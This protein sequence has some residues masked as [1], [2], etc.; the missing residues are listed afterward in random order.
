MDLDRLY[1][2]LRETTVQLRKGEVIHGDKPLVDALKAAKAPEDYEQLPGGVV[3]IDAMP[4]VSEAWP[5]LERVDLEFLVIGVNKA[6]AEKHRAEFISILNEY[7]QPDRLAGGPS[8]IEV[9]AEIGDQGAAFQL[10]ALGKVLGIWDVIT[11]A[12]MGFTGA[13]AQQMAG[14]GMVMM[15][16][17]Q[18]AA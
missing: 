3:T 15:T 16:G 17:Y 8:Y 4:H 11:P 13:V 9:G 1:E 7:P 14:A 18:R 5:E 12:T 10:F 2:I 6:A